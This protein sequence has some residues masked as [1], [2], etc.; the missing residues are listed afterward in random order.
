MDGP[1]SG[2]ELLGG[3]MLRVAQQERIAVRATLAEMD[4][5]CLRKRRYALGVPA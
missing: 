2:G 3:C 4:G 1:A 5:I